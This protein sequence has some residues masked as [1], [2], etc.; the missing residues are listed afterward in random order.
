MQPLLDSTGQEINK[1]VMV[2]VP[3]QDT[4]A[5]GFMYDLVRLSVLMSAPNSGAGLHVVATRGTVLPRQRETLARVALERDAT[6]ILWLD[7]DMRFPED[8]LLRL[9]AHNAPIVGTTY[10]SRRPP[11]VPTAAV[12][13]GTLLYVDDGSTGLVEAERIGF[14]C[15]LTSTEVF[16]RLEEPWFHIGYSRVAKDY[17]GEDV[18]FCCMAREAG[19]KVLVDLD[20]SK[21]VKHLGEAPYAYQHSLGFKEQA[22]AK[23]FKVE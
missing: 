20:L 5:T 12:P 9:L 13:G 3:A 17:M 2:A 10:T 4:V 22:K 1:R 7:S 8:A 21:E 14:G 23:G 11:F 18:Y 15:V 19:Y 6:H 16:K